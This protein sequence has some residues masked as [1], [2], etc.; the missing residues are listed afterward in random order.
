MYVLLK[1]LVFNLCVSGGNYLLAHARTKAAGSPMDVIDPNVFED[2]A[3]MQYNTLEILGFWQLLPGDIKN[4]LDGAIED[5]KICVGS[6][7][8]YS[9]YIA[10]NIIERMGEQ[11][12]ALYFG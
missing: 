4:I 8:Y 3:L 5:A 12:E 6:S 10:C 1:D 9:K 2:I 7:D 11:Y